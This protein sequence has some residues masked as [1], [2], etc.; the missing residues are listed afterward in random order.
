MQE[1]EVL[2]LKI[3]V[4]GGGNEIGAS[5]LH[6][7]I[8]GTHLLFDA[9]MRMH[10]DDPLPA[11]GMLQELGGVDAILVTHAHADHIGALPIVKMMYPHAPVYATTPTLDLMRVMMQDSYRILESRCKLEHKLIPY[12]EQQI[13]DLLQA[14]LA[15]PAGGRLQIGGA[16]ITAY[17][18]GHILGAVMFGVSGGGEKLL[19][20][21]DISFRAGRT[22]PGVKV[23]YNFHPDVVVMESTY[24]NRIHLD[25][26]ME[27]KRLAENVAEVVANGGFVLI[28]AFALGR[29]QE[30]LLILQDYMEKGLIPSF[31][32]YVDGLVTTVSRIY[33]G[34]PQFLKGPV[35]HRIRQNDDA[36]LNE[37]RCFAV[38]DKKHREQI[39]QGKPCCIVASSGML[40]GG[41]SLWYAE[42]LIGNEKN[43]VFI[44]GYQDEESPGRKLL[45]LAEGSDNTLDINGTVHQ[46][47][48][49]IDKYG[50]S[51]HADAMEMVRFI[52]EL[53]P[54]HTLLVHGDDDARFQLAEKIDPRFGPLLVENG[55][56]Y[57]FS[58]RVSGKGVKGK[59]YGNHEKQI[60]LDRW[61]GHN[62]LL[63]DAKR[64]LYP[65][66][67][68]GVH[69]KTRTLI[70]QSFHKKTSIKVTPS[71]VSE[72][73]GKWDGS[74][75]ELE[76][77][78][79]A[80]LKYC[81]PLLTQI[82]WMSLQKNQHYALE[83]ICSALGTTGMDHRLA[84]SLALHA[85]PESN[86]YR[87][88]TDGIDLPRYMMDEQAL[89]SLQEMKLPIQGSRMD[90]AAALDKTR[91][92]LQ[93]HPRFV[94]CGAEGL[95]TSEPILVVHF[96]FPDAVG[97]E[98]RRQIAEEVFE[99][100]GWSVRFS[101]S[102]RQDQLVQ[103]VRSVL[104]PSLNGNPSIHVQSKHIVVDCLPPDNW[105]EINQQFLFIT[106]Y[107]LI[108]KNSETNVSS[109]QEQLEWISPHRV[110]PM[111]NNRALQ[112]MKKWSAEIGATVYKA[113]IHQD[114]TGRRMEL[115]FISPQVGARYVEDI[116]RLADLIGMPV[117]Y[118]QNPKQ[119]EILAL[120][121][122]SIP[123]SWGIIKNPSIHTDK[124]IIT[125]KLQPKTQIEE[126]E[127]Q[128]IKGMIL[129]KT[130]YELLIQV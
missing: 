121:K 66:I 43:A 109:P 102:V 9:G 115:H 111:E 51:A 104:G 27:E 46:V 47:R 106:G 122:E 42:R 100:T 120:V 124:G 62:L 28:P 61:I 67:C 87:V 72:T 101:D 99:Q 30:I 127:L 20:T 129:E 71:E 123:L 98:E 65:A 77:S 25:R 50:L 91:E 57:P 26:N 1:A 5:C 36:F 11:L 97:D 83:E 82:N 60:E 18:A 16:E 105:E 75:L 128:K 116:R 54:A 93:G 40:I 34:Y 21:G 4:L 125:V 52:E 112:E 48:C 56:T 44:T 108:L 76:E 103:L 45:A 78:L 107:R 17:R 126:E 8:N 110:Q 24:G 85:L 7:E 96:D 38:R 69:G 117:S 32:I 64:Q 37:E 94:R 3:T 89:I 55:I 88:K 33:R 113:S 81:R 68:I 53:G 119:N 79:S 23:P 12:T 63:R 19:V 74:V 84:V 22:I 59:K 29:S 86:V 118:N 70:C 15:F 114:P 92:L 58:P 41:A 35:A 95:D 130:G 39:L 90:M 2:A 10:Q 14:M 73:L 13:H 80:T 31:P 6:V 49:R